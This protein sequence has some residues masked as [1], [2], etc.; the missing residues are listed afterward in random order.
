MRD[1]FEFDLESDR[2]LPFQLGGY[3][4]GQK[5]P[6][7]AASWLV[8]RLHHLVK[9]PLAEFFLQDHEETNLH[10]VAQEPGVKAMTLIVLTFAVEGQVSCLVRGSSLA[11]INGAL[12]RFVDTLLDEPA[13]VAEGVLVL[14]NGERYGWESS[15]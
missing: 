15:P 13:Q 7:S 9:M 6:I 14:P 11:E 1:R 8:A 3:A 10:L 5:P 2:R 12:K 4:P